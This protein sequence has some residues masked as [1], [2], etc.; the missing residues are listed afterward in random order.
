[1]ISLVC[2][3]C[4]HKLSKNGE[5]VECKFCR[6]TYHN[7]EGVVS[8]LD[9]IHPFYSGRYVVTR[10]FENLMPKFFGP[11]RYPFYRLFVEI[12]MVTRAERF[13]RH[14]L[15]GKK[16][17]KILDLACGGGWKFLTEYGDVTGIDISFNSL[18]NA[19][20]LY[21]NVYL[22]D[23][24]KL[25]FPDETFDVVTSIDFFEHI[26]PDKKQILLKEINRVLKKGGIV[27]KYIP[28]DSKEALTK[29]TK[30]YPDLYEKYW[31]HQDDHVGLES[32]YKVIN[33]F[34]L[35]GFKIVKYSHCWVNILMP[36]TYIKYLDND[37]RKKSKFIDFC[38]RFSK[39][40]VKNNIIFGLY[41]L[42]M[43][44]ITDIADHLSPINH[45]L[46]FMICA[47]KK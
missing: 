2:P 36:L 15:F 12:N 39:L 41:A 23:A 26:M 45:G 19:K 18:K 29:F 40:I 30:K 6:R 31:L 14:R 22:A 25:P 3:N 27:M 7:K 17:L 13:F 9:T 42:L 37:Y 35:A 8:F 47:K 10:D 32:P 28:M 20:K 33:R 4:K 11:F 24:N 5:V 46:G 43:G 1:M 44:P 16:N 38:V 34:K 21:E